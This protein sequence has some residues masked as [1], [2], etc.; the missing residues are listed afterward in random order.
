M[1]SKITL[2]I[3][4]LLV[5]GAVWF[6]FSNAGGNGEK[7]TLLPAPTINQGAPLGNAV[8]KEGAA[9]VVLYTDT[10]FSPKSLE[11]VRGE[12]VIF[13]N[14]TDRELWVASAPHPTHGIYPEFDEKTTIGNGETYEFVFEK[15]GEWKYHNHMNPGDSG[16]VV[17]K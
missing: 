17:V 6:V 7:I 3:V 12:K 13:V 15:S 9:L 2:A 11:I 16:V 5:L 14:S 10:G 4:V 8:E 1:N